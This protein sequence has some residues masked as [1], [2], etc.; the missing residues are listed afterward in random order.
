MIYKGKRWVVEHHTQWGGP[1]RMI[2]TPPNL[3]SFRFWAK[4]FKEQDRLISVTEQRFFV[5]E[6]D[7]TD[8]E[9]ERFIEA[10]RCQNCRSK[11][12]DVSFRDGTC[13]ECAEV[14]E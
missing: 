13:N 10:V 9:I 6:H 11:T 1:E 14:E 8:G 3:D 12:S 7:I 4:R 5:M 2:F